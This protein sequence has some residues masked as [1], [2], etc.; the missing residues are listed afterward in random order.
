VEEAELHSAGVS[1]NGI[2]RIYGGIAGANWPEEIDMLTR[3]FRA[4]FNARNVSVSNDCVV[5]L[6]GGTEKSDA[7]VL[8]AGSGFN[9]AVMVDGRIRHVFNNYVDPADQGGQALGG[10][11]LQAVF[12]SHLGIRGKTVLTQKLM[13]YFGYGEVDQ[14]LLGRDR[15]KL[16]YP[17]QTAVPILIDAALQNDAAALDIIF[18][19]STSIARYAAGSLKKYGLIGKDCDIVLS[20]GVF[21]SEHPLFFET[22]AAEIHRVSSQACVVNAE[23]EPVVGAALLGLEEAGV[24]P[25]ALETCR[26]SARELGLVRKK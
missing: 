20:G 16:K 6:R 4:R 15:G 11:A 5:A 12:E 22:I 2:T 23:Y 1:K 13:D 10:R 9:G 3:E 21:K 24:P 8:C 14:L 7:I 26:Q 18:S 25:Q 19:F 17:L